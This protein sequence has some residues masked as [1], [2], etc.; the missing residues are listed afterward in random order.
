[1]GRIIRAGGRVTTHRLDAASQFTWG[2]CCDWPRTANADIFNHL[3]SLSAP[4]WRRQ[5]ATT[6]FFQL[7][8]SHLRIKLSSIYGMLLI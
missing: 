6:N 5:Y 7:K 4:G 8:L 2:G 1:M 3:P